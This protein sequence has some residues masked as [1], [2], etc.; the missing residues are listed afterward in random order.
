MLG[1]VFCAAI[2]AFLVS[3]AGCGGTVKQTEG[4]PGDQ[5]REDG[6]DRCKAACVT[7]V[8]CGLGTPSCDCACA[9]CPAGSSSC[10]CPCNCESEPLTASKCESNCAESVQEVLD[11]SPHCDQAMVAVLDCVASATCKAAGDVPC[12]AEQSTLK[13]CESTDRASTPPPVAGGT[14]PGNPG[15]PGA[16]TCQLGSGSTVPT[17]R[18]GPA[19]GD[20]L[21]QSGWDECSDG[22]SYRVECHAT[23]GTPLAC[24]CIVDGTL[25]SSFTSSDCVFSSGDADSQC[26]WRLE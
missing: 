13:A 24:E 12:K 11:D 14:T 6:T 19:P 7:L 26:G 4:D 16:I 3:A 23:A 21:C 5:L 22:R 9:P 20:L 15:G 10:E 2:G 18:S 25:E 1:R 17:G 8:A